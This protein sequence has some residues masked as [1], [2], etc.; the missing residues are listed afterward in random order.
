MTFLSLKLLYPGHFH[1]TRGNHESINMNLTYGF[2][3][4]VVHKCDAKVFDVSRP[5]LPACGL[6]AGPLSAG[7]SISWLAVA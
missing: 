2:K 1:M 6:L 4:E 3:G 5:S 7:S